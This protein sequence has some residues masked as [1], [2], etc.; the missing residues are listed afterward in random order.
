MSS[1]G[2]YLQGEPAQALLVPG[3]CSEFFPELNL[4]PRGKLGRDSRLVSGGK[5]D[6]AGARQETA[7]RAPPDKGFVHFHDKSHNV[8][9]ESNDTRS[10]NIHKSEL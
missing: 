7:N 6:L 4:C 9:R 2:R 5:K 1:S 10:H 8:T 3:G